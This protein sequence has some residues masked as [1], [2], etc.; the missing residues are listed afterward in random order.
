M[1]SAGSQSMPESYFYLS[2]K[3]QADAL[4]AGASAP[5]R[6]PHCLEKDIWVVS[7]HSTLFDS[8]WARPTWYSKEARCSLRLTKHPTRI[9]KRL[10]KRV[11]G[12][13]PVS[14]MVSVQVLI[15]CDSVQVR[16]TSEVVE[17]TVTNTLKLSLRFGVIECREDEITF[18]VRC[19]QPGSAT[20]PSFEKPSEC[21]IKSRGQHLLAEKTAVAPRC[22]IQVESSPCRCAAGECLHA[23]GVTLS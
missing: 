6:P 16:A 13:G 11:D 1:P 14:D 19:I 5:G 23:R 22:Q 4:A 17:T 9:A 18:R 7:A 3:D 8:E 2:A 15:P 12:R 21:G 20:S 10:H